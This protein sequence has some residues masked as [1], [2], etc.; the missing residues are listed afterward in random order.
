MDELDKEWMKMMGEAAKTINAGTVINQA[1]GSA[2]YMGG[3]HVHLHQSPS[4]TDEPTQPEP[5]APIDRR[6]DTAEARACWKE[7][8]KQNLAEPDRGLYRWTGQN[9]ELGYMVAKAAHKLRVL[10]DN[11]CIQWKPFQALF[12]FDDSQ[13]RQAKNAAKDADIRQI[14][15][16]IQ[17]AKYDRYRK[18]KIIFA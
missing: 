6:L 16:N 9:K 14:D 3:Q 17:D 4:P 1:P 8:C 12:G 13:L 2:L 5:Q 7:L 11:G 15:Q 18:I 10:D